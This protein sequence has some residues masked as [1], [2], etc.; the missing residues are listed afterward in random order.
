MSALITAGAVWFQL[1]GPVMGGV[2]VAVTG[3]VGKVGWLVPL[4]LVVV[5]GERL[6]LRLAYSRQR[7]D[8]DAAEEILSR[9]E[10]LLGALV[11]EPLSVGDL[12]ARLEPPA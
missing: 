4:T 2:R 10:A 6:L 11:E 1:G 5:P 3:C 7:F 9:L 12:A 8:E